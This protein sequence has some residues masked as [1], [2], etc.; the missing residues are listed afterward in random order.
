MKKLLKGYLFP[1]S[2]SGFCSPE[3]VNQMKFNR[4]KVVDGI[5]NF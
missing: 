5:N 3:K 1:D 4:K 2:S